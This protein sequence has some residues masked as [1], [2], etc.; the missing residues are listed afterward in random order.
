MNYEIAKQL[1]E[2]GFPFHHPESKWSEYIF[3]SLPELIEACGGCLS[4]IKKHNGNWWAVSHCGHTEH[5]P[6]GNNLEENARTAEEAVANLWLALNIH[7]EE[8]NIVDKIV[9]EVKNRYE[10]MHKEMK[11]QEA[12]HIAEIKKQ[13]VI[14]GIK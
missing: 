10:K 13:G 5:E 1:K 2:A 12:K 9:K 6:G 8:E 14:L 3:P 11:E 4:H 7:E